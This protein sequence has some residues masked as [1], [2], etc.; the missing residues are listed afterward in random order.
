MLEFFASN[1][2]YIVL[3]IILIVWAGIVMYLF[4]LDGRLKKLESSKG[5]E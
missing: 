1:Q 2:M 5:G 4:R 3:G